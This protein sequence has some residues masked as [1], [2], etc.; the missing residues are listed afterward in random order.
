MAHSELHVV[1]ASARIGSGRDCIPVRCVLVGSSGQPACRLMA[2]EGWLRLLVVG[3]ITYMG[4]LVFAC[5]VG[6][7]VAVFALGT[8]V[9]VLLGGPGRCGL[10]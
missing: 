9:G 4:M 3:L 10:T 1:G 2:H 7:S 5:R 6:A 8:P